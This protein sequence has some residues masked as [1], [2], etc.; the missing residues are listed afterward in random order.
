MECIA[1]LLE[2]TRTAIS[3][4]GTTALLY[5]V[6]QYLWRKRI[7]KSAHDPTSPLSKTLP[8]PPGDF[9]IPFLG[10]TLSWAVEGKNFNSSRRKKHGTVFSTHFLGN[11]IVKVSGASNVKQILQ[12]EHDKVT[13]IWP[14]SIR[15]IFGEHAITHSPEDKHKYLRKLALKGFSQSS[16]NGYI[17]HLRDIISR[18]TKEWARCSGSK[19]IYEDIKR[20]TFENA[21]KSMAGYSFETNENLERH[22]K[23]FEDMLANLFSLPYDLPVIGF[24]K[25]IRNS[26]QLRDLLHSH[27]RDKLK[28][29]ISDPDDVEDARDVLHHMIVADVS[30]SRKRESKDSGIE[31]DKSASEDEERQL[32]LE[33]LKQIAI[34]L[35]FGGYSTTNSAVSSLII[36]LAK[37]PDV[38]K[39]LEEELIENGLLEDDDDSDVTLER[40][41]K[42]SYLEQVIKE[43]LRVMPPIL[44]GYRKALKTF[45]IGNYRIPKGWT[46]VYNIRDTHE[47]EFQEDVDFDPERF[48]RESWSP[49]KGNRFRWIPF[50]G[51]PRVCLGKEYAKLAIKLTAIEM[52]KRFKSWRFENDQPPPMFAVPTL[53]PTNG[54]PVTF[55]LR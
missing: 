32:T 14:T 50:G 24:R 25:G 2:I 22:F 53:H 43:V 55:E 3:Y 26:R 34:E 9:G 49:T 21:A 5:F 44:G 54:L 30:A 1:F 12:G 37:Y 18:K 17:P 23:V 13:T 36:Q 38:R 19:R 47:Y 11:P 45:Q 4:L 16:L 8:L 33:E 40:I 39:K 6:A 15:R 31:S 28:K 29:T 10:E 20:M 51:G 7:L 52:I 41:Q 35:M 42:L 27:L 48:S 46:V